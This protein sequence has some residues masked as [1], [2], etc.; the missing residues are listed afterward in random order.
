M[1]ELERTLA[2]LDVDW[3]PTPS[4]EYPL[5]RRRRWPLAL[6][7]VVVLAVAAAFAVP[8]SRGAI[9]R[10]LHIGGETIERVQTLPPAQ[11]RPLRD[12]L[13]VPITSAAART[14][15]GRP[16]AVGGVPVYRDGQAVSAIVDGGL[17]LTELRAGYPL[18]KKLAFA[19]GVRRI[20]ADTIWVAGRHV[21]VPPTLPPRYAGN[22]LV[23]ERRGI[24]YRLEGR[25]LTLAR[26]R[27]FAAGLSY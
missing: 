10:F 14:L 26:A 4:F 2:E 20:D 12:S 18:V 19:A 21:Y 24:T 27:S 7:L 3:P 1:T 11:E 8:Q 22:T 15:L 25:Q 23:W 5:R 6:A 9:L 13:G 17:V 16:F